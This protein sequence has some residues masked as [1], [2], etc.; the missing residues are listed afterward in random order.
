MT[1]IPSPHGPHRLAVETVSEETRVAWLEWL[2][3]RLL[4][5]VRDDEL[6]P[7]AARRD[8]PACLP[9]CFLFSCLSLSSSFSV[10]RALTASDATV[11]HYLPVRLPAGATRSTVIYKPLLAVMGSSL[12]ALWLE[13]FTMMQ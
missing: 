8:L 12:P 5:H 10:L 1:F 11:W 3:Q 9:A 13:G 2:G 6:P 7:P 4:H